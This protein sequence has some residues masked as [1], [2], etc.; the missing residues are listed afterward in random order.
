MQVAQK[1]IAEAGAKA[2]AT[3]SW[4]VAASLGCEDGE[5]VPFKLVLDNV[6][7]IVS[8]TDLPVTIDIES[9]YG[10]SSEEIRHTIRSI[11][12]CGAVGV[13][14]EDQVIGEVS[15]YSIEK[16]C[17]RISSAREEANC[18]SIPLFINARTDIFL[19]V[20]STDHTFDH[21]S[22]AIERA[23]AYKD[24]GA[25]GFFVPG[26]KDTV[27]IKQL[28]EKSPLPINIMMMS[29]MV[30]IEELMELGVSRVSYGPMPYQIA[31]S[32][33]RDDV[34]A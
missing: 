34:F 4:S 26:L 11:I 33:L 1:K 10:D 22:Q 15:L 31:M 24:S 21:L 13:N 20:D 25:S 2:I 9:G 30:S 19:K 23:I 12:D 28:C 14:L 17:A 5:K 32:A 18:A 29:D 3:G 6:R 8:V 7:R 16:Q 27:L